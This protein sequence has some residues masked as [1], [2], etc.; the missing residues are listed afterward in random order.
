MLCADGELGVVREAGADEVDGLLQDGR[1]DREVL[2]L[3]LAAVCGGGGRRHGDRRKGLGADN[4]GCH[5]ARREGGRDRA[6]AGIG[7]HCAPAC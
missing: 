2:L 4:F 1:G 3:L 7:V 5:D 6:S